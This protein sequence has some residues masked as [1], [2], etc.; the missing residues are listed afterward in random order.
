MK[1]KRGNMS[2]IFMGRD[3]NEPGECYVIDW[4][5]KVKLR[6]LDGLRDPLPRQIICFVD[7]LLTTDAVNGD[8]NIEN[9]ACKRKNTWR[10]APKTENVAEYTAEVHEL[11]ATFEFVTKVRT[12]VHPP[13][14]EIDDEWIPDGKHSNSLSSLSLS[15]CL[16]SS[17]IV[18]RFPLPF[19]VFALVISIDNNTWRDKY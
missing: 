18:F 6:P 9:V 5:K 16:L 19:D 1:S 3:T 10:G 13:E 14:D 4:D 7:N 2:F 11:H 15:L 8:V 17:Q 12:T